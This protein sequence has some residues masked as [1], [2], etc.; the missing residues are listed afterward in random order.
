MSQSDRP[1]L[2]WTGVLF[3]LATNLFLPTA[4]DTL[5]APWLGAGLL[6]GLTGIA[7]PLLAGA[8]TARYTMQRGGMHAFLGGLMSVPI[9]GFAVFPGNWQLAILAGAFCTLGGAITELLMRRG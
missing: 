5:G 9:L 1:P 4:V 3:A 2:Q 6:W 7:A 8:L